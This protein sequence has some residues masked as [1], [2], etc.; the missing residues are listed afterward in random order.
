VFNGFDRD[1]LYDLEA[2]P[3]EMV[4]VLD[5]PAYRETR[6][7]LRRLLYEQMERYGDPYA[8]NCYRAPRY[9]A[10]P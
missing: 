2:D 8:Q 3:H 5:V 6:D 10:R 7:A 4:N 9:L 1:E